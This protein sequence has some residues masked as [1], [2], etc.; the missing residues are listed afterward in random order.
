MNLYCVEFYRKTKQRC[1]MP[2]KIITYI[3]FLSF[4][5]L[6]GCYSFENISYNQFA[7]DA[8]SGNPPTELFINTSDYTRYHCSWNLLEMEVDSISIK[9]TTVH[10]KYE[11]PYKGKIAIKDINYIKAKYFDSWSTIALVVV[12]VGSAALLFALID[13]APKS[14]IGIY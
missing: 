5:H 8:T 9:G 3:L 10:G 13:A 7:E 4:I 1:E 2:K 12:I 11:E 6:L 14:P